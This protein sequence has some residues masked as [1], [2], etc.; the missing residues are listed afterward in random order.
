MAETKDIK[1]DITYNTPLTPEEIQTISKKIVADLEAKSK[2]TPEI[3]GGFS[4]SEH[5]KVVVAK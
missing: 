5:T 1:V 3:S 2:I 4:K